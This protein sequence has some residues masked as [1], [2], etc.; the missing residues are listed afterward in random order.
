MLALQTFRLPALDWRSVL[1]AA[2]IFIGFL[3][4][5]ELS[6]TLY[7]G[8][9]VFAFH[10][11][12][13][14]A[15]LVL[16]GVE[17]WP[18][19]FFAALLNY[20]QHDAS[21]LL[22]LTYALANSI[23]AVTGAYILRYV[24][25]KAS[26]RRMRD[27]F[28]LTIVA[29]LA[30]TI[31]PTVGSIGF[32]LS[33]Y[34]GGASVPVSFGSRWVGHML[35]LLIVAPF[36]IRWIAHP[37]FDR[38][39]REVI[40]IIAA[41]TLVF[42]IYGFLF[43]TTVEQING[44][45]LAY[46]IFPPLFW[47]ALRLGS[48]F[49]T[50]ALF[51]TSMIALTGTGLGYATV[52]STIPTGQLLFLTEIFLI[53]IAVIFLIVTAVEEERRT[54]TA[55]LRGH[56]D[57]LQEALTK[58][59][60]EDNAK[61][62]FVATLAHELR[63]PL[64]PLLSTIELLTLRG[65]DAKDFPAMLGTMRDRVRTM[66]RLLDDLLD[67]SRITHQKLKLQKSAVDI[68]GIVKSSVESMSGYMQKRS[69]TFNVTLPLSEK[70]VLE[71]DPIRVEQ[72]IVNLLHNAAKYT[73]VGGMIHLSVQREQ[74]RAMISVR[75][76]GIGIP[77][78]MLQRIFE[79]FLQVNT[80]NGS[81]LGI[82]LSLT[83]RLVELHGGSIEAHSA[84]EGR[85]SEFTVRLPLLTVSPIQPLPKEASA[86]RVEHAPSGLRILLADDNHAASETLGK[87]LEFKGYTVN[88]S[89]DG[90]STI[91][92]AREFDPHIVMLDI[93][94]PDM[95]GYDVART[96]RE[97]GNDAALIA[98]T[99]YGQAEDKER[100]KDAGFDHHLTKPVGIA[101]LEKTLALL[102]TTSVRLQA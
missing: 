13:A 47:I 40:E 35:S 89:H 83:Q 18:V 65:P 42:A 81:G 6:I 92:A 4:S 36:L 102:S 16:A 101:D 31:V 57:Q 44:I 7:E 67:I 79:P 70:M 72:I 37:I 91:R 55:R 95:S 28:W 99:G 19:I 49:M 87:L 20:W 45:P 94:L 30:S 1:T 48:R 61:T 22:M 27:I 46:L 53:V 29:L 59:R 82:G 52:S 58:I 97:S 11:G 3:V 98:I 51:G 21:A 5:S 100:A 24:G 26:L 80:K 43:F 54:A 62:Q 50:L 77:P 73:A 38:T 15:A 34:L 17:F 71:A 60:S 63:N 14:L 64:A 93:G 39:W 33:E 96:L 84:G 74:D 12:I 88:F 78:H 8:P 23:Q 9:A 68:V 90:A 76:T 2:V 32:M 25:F 69:L 10:S 86:E 75:D 56:I 41:M 66:S 85:G